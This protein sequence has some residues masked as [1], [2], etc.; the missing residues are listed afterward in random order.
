MRKAQTAVDQILE[1]ERWLVTGELGKTFEVGTAFINGMGNARSALETFIFLDR[2]FPRY[3]FLCGIAGTLDPAKADL[4]DVI[5]AKSV[6][7]WNLNKVTK[8]SAKA[9]ADGHGKYL[10]LGDHYFRKDISTV[11]EHSAHWNRRLTRFTVDHHKRLMSNSDG[12]LV[13]TKSEL[14]RPATRDNILHYEKLVSWEYVLS[15]ETIRDEIRRDP[16]GGLAIEMEGGGFST[17]ITRRN[18]EVNNRQK[19]TG[20]IPGDTV[21]FVFRGIS[22]LC[23]NKGHEPQEWR[24]I[25]MFNAASALVD[26]LGTFSDNDLLS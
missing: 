25:A 18:E 4:G 22:D 3:V 7:W 19:Q 21:G 1:I 5:I 9:A 15:E 26:F 14:Q 24:K 11:G 16:E 8:D 2:V 23:H 20:R 17:S 12:A 13:K 6:Q 10:R